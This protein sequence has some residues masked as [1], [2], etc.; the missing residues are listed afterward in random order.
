ML[1]PLN[2][3]Y[4]AVTTVVFTTVTLPLLYSERFPLH[5]PAQQ[6]ITAASMAKLIHRPPRLLLGPFDVHVVLSDE[7]VVDFP[8]L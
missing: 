2:Y 1:H 8:A 7:K 4:Y 6:Q 5:I 3:N